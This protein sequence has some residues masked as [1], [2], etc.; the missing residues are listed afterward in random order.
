M[1]HVD[2]LLQ[3]SYDLV[4]EKPEALLEPVLIDFQANQAQSK[5]NRHTFSL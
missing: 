5:W 2:E 1:Q 4:I 3:K